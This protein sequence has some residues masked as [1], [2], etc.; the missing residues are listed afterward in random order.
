MYNSFL[1]HR[2][3]ALALT[4]MAIRLCGAALAVATRALV[5]SKLT[6]TEVIALQIDLTHLTA[7]THQSQLLE[8]WRLTCRSWSSQA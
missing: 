6:L 8:E 7:S 4:K 3:E 2:R 5:K 1:A